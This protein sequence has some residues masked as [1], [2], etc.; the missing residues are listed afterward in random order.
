M[1]CFQWK[2]AN[3][4]THLWQGQTLL[5]LTADTAS[6]IESKWL[7][8]WLRIWSWIYPGQKALSKLISLS[9]IQNS[10]SGHAVFC[11]SA[12]I[13]HLLWLYLHRQP[14][15][16]W[17][18]PCPCK[19]SLHCLGIKS[20]SLALASQECCSPGTLYRYAIWIQKVARDLILGR[21]VSWIWFSHIKASLF[22]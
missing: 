7:L 8:L 21:N 20:N 15:W 3:K 22:I 6:L 4:Q 17:N 19:M 2:K 16:P 13:L 18:Y 10:N 11:V 5:A 9:L 1:T 12:P 14:F